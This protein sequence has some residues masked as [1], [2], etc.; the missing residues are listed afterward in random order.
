M[1]W[2]AP[3]TRVGQVRTREYR[4]LNELTVDDL[5]HAVEAAGFRITK[6]QLISERV[7][8]PPEVRGM[9]LSRLGISGI[10]LLAR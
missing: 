7:P 5:G 1:S 4:T 8:L 3:T 2:P 9:D 6:L 10:M